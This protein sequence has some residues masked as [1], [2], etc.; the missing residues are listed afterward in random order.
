[1]KKNRNKLD[2]TV[3][4]KNNRSIIETE[5]HPIKKMCFVGWKTI[6]KV[7]QTFFNEYTIITFGSKKVKIDECHFDKK[8]R[9]NF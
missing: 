7:K 9:K 4:C 2:W 3:G 1:M 5:H 6:K 8:K